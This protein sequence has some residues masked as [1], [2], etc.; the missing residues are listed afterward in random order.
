MNDYVY[1]CEEYY[2][3]PNFR[4]SSLQEYYIPDDDLPLSTSSCSRKASGTTAC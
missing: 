3:Q 1:F 2:P 4:L